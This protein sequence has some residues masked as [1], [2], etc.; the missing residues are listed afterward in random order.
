[1][2]VG[3]VQHRSSFGT[4][5]TSLALAF[6][7]NNT[8]QNLLNYLTGG[9]TNVTTITAATDSNSNTIAN[10]T[11]VSSS[12][13]GGARSDYVASANSGA[14]TVTAH[15]TGTTADIHLHIWEI[16]G[17]VTTSPVRD[18]GTVA[19]SATASVS[20]TG[21]STLAGDAV[22]GF[23]SDDANSRTLVAGSGYSPS[24][25][26]NNSTGGD[27]DLSEFEAA[28]ASGT[29]TATCTGN[30]TDL[31]GQIIVTF[32]QAASGL[33]FQDDSLP[34]FIAAQLEPNVS[35]YR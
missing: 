18:T 33:V 3:V 17:C 34:T 15:T 25:L 20:T 24:E 27:A 10:A 13:A 6:S 31:M 1:M 30:S 28:P 14:N 11:S 21:S 32:K 5:V 23:F 4:H 26:T 22:I 7:T 16:S 12:T 9:G 2:A 8:A 19:S 29:Q 35:I